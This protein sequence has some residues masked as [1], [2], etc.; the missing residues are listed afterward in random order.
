[1]VKKVKFDEIVVVLV[2]VSSSNSSKL[3]GSSIIMI[4]ESSINN[5]IGKI[6]GRVKCGMGKC[7]KKIVEVVIGKMVRKMWS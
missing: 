5:D 2:V 3:E 7:V 1:M 6:N 4:I